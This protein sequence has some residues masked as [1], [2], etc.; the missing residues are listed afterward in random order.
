MELHE[1]R[2]VLHY[3]GTIIRE[4]KPSV[5]KMRQKNPVIFRQANI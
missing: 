2:K 1:I 5:Y 4:N 3:K